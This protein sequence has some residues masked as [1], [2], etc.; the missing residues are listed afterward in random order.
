MTQDEEIKLL[1]QTIKA[2]Y[3]MILNYRLGK[4]QLPEWV[5]EYIEKA[6]K[7]YGNNLTKII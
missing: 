6:K 1:K 3:K 7:K 5:F 4:S 2:L